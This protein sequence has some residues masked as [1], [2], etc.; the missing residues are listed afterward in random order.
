M[1]KSIAC[2]ML[3]T[4]LA[5][6]DGGLGKIVTGTYTGTGGYG[7]NNRKTYPKRYSDPVR[8]YTLLRA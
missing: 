6:A 8:P 3:A 4:A 7:T 2:L 5:G 1:K